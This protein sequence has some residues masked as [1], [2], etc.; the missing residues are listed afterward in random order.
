MSAGWTGRLVLAGLLVTGA[1]VFCAGI[2]WGLP[3]RD[4]DPF[5]CGGRPAWSGKLILELVGNRPDDPTVGADVDLDPLNKTGP[6]WL[7]ETDAQRAAI[8]IRYRLYTYQPDEM[9]T[10]RSLGSMK[11]G[12][13]KF[14]PKLYQYGGLWIYPVGALLKIASLAGL[15][16]VDADRAWYLDHPEEFGRFYVVARLYVVA[17]ALVGVAAVYW[18]ARRFSDGSIAVAATA[19][20]CYIIMPVVVNMAHEAKPHLPAAVLMLLAI[21]ASIKYL[22]TA[23]AR[24]WLAT[25]VLCG[26]AFGMV[27]SALPAF[28]LIPVMVLLRRGGWASRLRRT[29][30]GLA[31]AAGVYLVT[32]PYIPINWFTNRAVL[33]SN[34]GNSLAMYELGRWREGLVNAAFLVAEGAGIVLAVLGAIGVI[35]FAVGAL[36]ASVARDGAEPRQKGTGTSPKALPDSHCNDQFGASP[37]LPLSAK[38]GLLL[39]APAVLILVQ[40]VALA[41]GKPGEYGRFAVL[42]DVLLAIAAVIAVWRALAGH[43]RRGFAAAALVVFTAAQGVPYLSGFLM[44]SSPD[45]SRL[46]SAARLESLLGSEPRTLAVLAEPAPYVMPPFDLFRWRLVLLPD[47][48]HAPG[49]LGD[50]LINVDISRDAAAEALGARRLPDPDRVISWA[51]RS[52]DLWALKLPAT[53]PAS[54]AAQ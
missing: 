33:Q 15:I 39:G 51:N 35:V 30:A 24:W 49:F 44:D 47:R 21:I 32:N 4:V 28:V 37:L 54:R 29:A 26:A 20:A 19:A 53:E 12:L 52:F 40:F 8:L 27:L 23:R 22:E 38:Q 16:R 43:Q 42:P 50:A 48:A 14:D 2:S 25:S 17:W 34:F 9:I 36:R 7:N 18:L 3:S 5:L 41:A 11:P 45:N 6:V 13:G 46:A 10:M 1:V 31:I